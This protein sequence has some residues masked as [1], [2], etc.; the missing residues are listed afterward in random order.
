MEGN[1]NAHADGCDAFANFYIRACSTGPQQRIDEG[2]FDFDFHIVRVFSI[3]M[4][5][6]STDFM[7]KIFKVVI[8]QCLLSF[9]RQSVSIRAFIDCSIVKT[10]EGVC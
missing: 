2:I 7:L 3:P 5:N 6:V 9:V 4:K 1:E 10:L 8:N